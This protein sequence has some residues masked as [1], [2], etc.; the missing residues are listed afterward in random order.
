MRIVPSIGVRALRLLPLRN[1]HMRSSSSKSLEIFPISVLDYFQQQEQ[2]HDWN[3]R[4]ALQSRWSLM[5]K[6]WKV[7]VDW[8]ETEY[9]IGVFAGEA[10][11]A[12]T[13]LRLGKNGRNLLQFKCRE[14]I[15]AFCGDGS[16]YQQRLSYVKDYLWGYC[17]NTDEQGYKVPDST[18]ADRFFG[19]WLPGNGLNH[20]FSPNTVY[21]TLQGGTDDGIMLVALTDIKAGQ[22]LYDD[23]RRHGDAPAWL[24]EFAKD[25]HVTL[26]FPD[27]NDFVGRKE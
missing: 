19:M 15:E 3:D 16:D 11:A 26:N 22:E 20:N 2:V 4:I 8:K 9:G 7:A 1:R 14:D 21:R 13:L 10:I 18:D 25:K 27:C 12:G 6:G 5:R 24:L 23:Y 17:T